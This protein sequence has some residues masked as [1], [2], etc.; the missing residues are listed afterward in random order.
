MFYGC[1]KLMSF[2]LLVP[3]TS[4]YN[5]PWDIS[6]WLK[7]AGTDATSRTLK[8]KDKAA[9]DAL[10]AK[11]LDENWKIG[12]CTVLDENGKAITE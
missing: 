6:N 11:K 3:A 12:N 8:V 9:Y 10:V 5:Y 2:T 1:S 4:I 7:D